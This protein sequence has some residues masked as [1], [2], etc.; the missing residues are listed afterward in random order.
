MIQPDFNMVADLRR[1]GSE[2]AALADSPGVAVTLSIDRLGLVSVSP[3][4]VDRWE[5]GEGGK[6]LTAMLG[7]VAVVTPR[8]GAKPPAVQ[9]AVDQGAHTWGRVGAQVPGQRTRLTIPSQYR[10]ALG[11]DGKRSELERVDGGRELIFGPLGTVAAAVEEAVPDLSD[12]RRACIVEDLFTNRKDRLGGP[13]LLRAYAARRLVQGAF[14]HVYGYDSS[15]PGVGLTAQL[16]RDAETLEDIVGPDLPKK[17]ALRPDHK[18]HLPKTTA[19]R[20]GLSQVSHIDCTQVGTGRDAIGVLT[21]HD[22]AKRPALQDESIPCDV[23][24]SEGRVT[25]PRPLRR[26]WGGAAVPK[27]EVVDTHHKVLI[28]REGRM[29]R[30]IHTALPDVPSGY[31]DRMA[32]ELFTPPGTQDGQISFL[33]KYATRKLIEGVLPQVYGGLA[34]DHGRE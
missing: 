22:A 32:E 11:I 3:A 2:F 14:V 26:E 20:L 17:H 31:R 19:A 25:I 12:S 28:M 30:A 7:N 33:R 6:T 16:N 24:Q 15:N 8:Q 34:E 10:K 1:E 18:V 5:F 9:A 29:A 13:S 21:P 27:L 23:Q 4:I